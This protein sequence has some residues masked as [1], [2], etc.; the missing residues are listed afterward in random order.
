M[1]ELA[2]AIPYH[3]GRDLLAHA[4]RS[5]LAQTDA[6]WSLLVCDDGERGEAR[7]VVAELGLDGDTRVRCVENA[8]N[9]GMAA[10][11][12]R[13]LDLADAP[14]VALLHA[15]DALLPGYVA[16]MR[17]LAARHPGATALYCDARVVDAAGAPVFSLADRVKPLFLPPQARGAREY[18]LAGE[19]SLRAL[20][21]GNFIMC[22]TL[23]YRAALL[24][25]RRFDPRWKQVQDLALTSGLLMDGDVLVGTRRVEYAYRRHEGGATWRQS[26]SLLRFEEEMALFDRVAE[27]AAALGWEGAART[28]RAKRIVRAHLALRALADAAAL[29]LSRARAELALALRR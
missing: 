16:C 21:A 20:M 25:G 15:D 3:R 17:D 29:R 19:R 13:C 2:I 9:L 18:E 8:R 27:R 4:V 26:E 5:V 11:W 10:N 23:C 24:R 28:A 6:A 1:S 12:N 22:P 7:A 14:L